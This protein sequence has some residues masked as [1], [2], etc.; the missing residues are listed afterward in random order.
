VKSALTRAGTELG[1]L[2]GEAFKALVR[3][4]FDRLREL[5]KTLRIAVQ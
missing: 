5:N 3:S 1:D 4:E 2:A